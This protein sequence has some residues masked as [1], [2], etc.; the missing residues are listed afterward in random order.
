MRD[1]TYPNFCSVCLETLWINLLRKISLIDYFNET[2]QEGSDS[3]IKT[4]VLEVGL[5]PL[6]QLRKRLVDSSE[7]YTI[8][9]KR[10][11]EVLEGFTNKTRVELDGNQAVGNY[12]VEVAFS[13]QE[14]KLRS[15]YLTANRTYIVEANCN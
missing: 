1:V 2:C 9:W 10:A 3:Q 14:V 15:E 13:T 8:I 11:N 12:T 7:S 4:K 6:A 5:I